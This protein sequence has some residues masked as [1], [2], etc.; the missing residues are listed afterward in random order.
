[1]YN[2]SLYIEQYW[3][4]RWGYWCFCCLLVPLMSFWKVGNFDSFYLCVYVARFKMSIYIADCTCI[5]RCF[6]GI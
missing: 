6:K 5:D 1:M 3:S 4:L 2:I